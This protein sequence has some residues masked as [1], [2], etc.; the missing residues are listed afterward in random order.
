LCTGRTVSEKS[1]T[2]PFPLYTRPYL[3]FLGTGDKI[4]GD[5]E[6]AR[7]TAGDFPNIQIE[8]LESG[9]LISVEHAEYVNNELRDF[10]NLE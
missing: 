2:G 4:V 1:G 5:A 9:H 8:M 7:K 3:L 6:F 10:L